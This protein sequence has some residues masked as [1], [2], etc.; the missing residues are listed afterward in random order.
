MKNGKG[1]VSIKLKILLPTVFIVTLSLTAVLL[2]VLISSTT[3]TNIL[4]NDYMY[5][6]NEHYANIIQG[7]LNAAMSGIRS[8][9]PVFEQNKLSG[10]TV[11]ENDIELLKQVLSQNEEIFGVYTLW[12]PN[13]YD[14]LD[15]K[16]VGADGH[17]DTGRFIP[18]VYRDSSGSALSPLTSY[19]EEGTG[20]YYL[21]PK[22][23]GEETIVD[24]FLYPLNG[25]DKLMTSIVLPLV[26]GGRFVGIVGMDI[27]VETLIEQIK[28]VKLFQSGYMFI[29]DSSGNMFYHPSSDLVGQAFHSFIGEE[30]VA[31]VNRALETGE[32][33]NFDSVSVVTGV[34]SRYVITPVPAAGKY[35]LVCT[36][37]PIAEIQEVT[38]TNIKYGIAAG[39]AALLL[40]VLLLL[41]LIAAIIRPVG[42][43][44][45]AAAAIES[46]NIDRE[47]TDLLGTIGSRDEIGVLANSMRRAAA[48]I[49]R[50]ERDVNMLGAAAEHNDLTADADDEEHSGV[51][52]RVIE[53]VEG[54]LRKMNDIIYR[55]NG[56]ASQIAASSGQV[57][58]GA[59][60]LSEGATEQ[61]GAVEELSASLEQISEKTKQNALLASKAKELS[62]SA[63][64]D[65]I[66]G[67]EKMKDMQKAMA[68]I[69]QSSENIS[70]IIKVIE[71]IAF[72]TNILAL[73]AAV[74]AARAGAHGKGFSVVAQEVKNLAQKSADAAKETAALIEGS[75]QNVNAGLVITNETAKMLENILISGEK[76]AELIS[77]IN[78]AS[79][80]QAL[81]IEQIN[82]GIVQVSKVVQ[83][84]AATSEESA[85]ASEEL[86]GNAEEL[87]KMVSIFKLI[88]T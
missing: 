54:L 64:D 79:G 83:D 60:A 58:A 50:I 17:D 39:C 19:E 7:N 5:E 42:K 31:L 32:R 65:S 29:T 22:R 38:E 18:Y 63:R 46:G 23:T 75:I 73:N 14:G 82:E 72:Q 74:E 40:T 76:T 62:L 37:V 16:Y 49:E 13:A 68:E 26:N 27:L 15:S 69:N 77:R 53:I 52:R 33:V 41:P 55:V 78:E 85:A 36:S 24:P 34:K 2:I 47:T 59:Q 87:K 71:D 4:S 43:L 28:D 25:E 80:E 84:V 44:T 67:N 61:A 6:S 70:S 30:E 8:L 3:R 1:F 11:R 10:H 66:S 45:K 56:A 86:A 48:A 12:E 81:A 20:D 35:W 51:F 21:I 88:D 9:K 57:S